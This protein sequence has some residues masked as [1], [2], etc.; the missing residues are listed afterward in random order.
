MYK[1]DSATWLGLISLGFVYLVYLIWGDSDSHLIRLCATVASLLL[2]LGILLFS[3]QS[4]QWRAILGEIPSPLILVLCGGVGLSVWMVSWWLMDMSNQ[5]LVDVAG[6]Y[7]PELAL[8]PNWTQ[9]V[10]STVVILPFSISI[11]VFGIMRT[12]LQ[13]IQRPT[14]LL[15]ITIYTATL[16][17]MITPEGLVGLLGYG[18]LGLVAA[19]VSLQ[20]RSLW[21]G[22]VAYAVFAYANLWLLDDLASVTFGLGYTDPEWL[23]RV[24]LSLFATLILL[25]IIRF[26]EPTPP[27]PE[28]SGKHQTKDKKEIP[29]SFTSFGWGSGMG[30]TIILLLYAASEIALRNEFNTTLSP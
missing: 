1:P 15:W 7:A 2:P 3:E 4:I 11:L 26:R 19:I 10:I 28:P 22:F 12:R 21:S 18:L 13:A 8:I 25:Q 17:I 5:A 27:E 20:T 14:A 30:V 23:L 9:R 24:I 6:V 29:P 16:S